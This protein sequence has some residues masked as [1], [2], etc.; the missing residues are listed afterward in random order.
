MSK[1]TL[2][3]SQ[4]L[5]RMKGCSKKTYKNFAGGNL[6]Y[7]VNNL[8]KNQIPMAYTGKGGTCNN[9]L[10]PSLT[11]PLNTNGINKTLPNT[12]PNNELKP[13]TFFLNP[14]TQKG[15]NCGICNLMKGGKRKRKPTYQLSSS[16]M[17]AGKKT[18]KKQ[19]GGNQ[20]IPYP[21][22]L[23]GSSW[24]SSI[25][26][27]SGVDG[28]QG[29]RNF[30]PYNNYKTDVQTAIKLTGAQPPFSIGGKKQ[31]GGSLSNF[32]GQDLI[33]LGRQFQYGLGSTYNA[34]AGYPAPVNPM[35]WK[36]Q[37]S[38][39]SNFNSIRLASK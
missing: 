19:F 36:G 1:K 17:V 37:L 4:K 34:L 31:R 8:K 12:G 28:I 21:N 16:L 7:S 3:K 35:P 9:N 33:N 30:L 23:V 15:G 13:T 26:D 32:L 29:N 38:N 24:S 25:K 14:Q 27:W 20:G 2:K 11:I 10:T 39:T 5:Y 18:K 6:A 22:G